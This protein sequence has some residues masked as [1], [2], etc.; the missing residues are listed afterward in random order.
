MMRDMSDPIVWIHG[1]PHAKEIFDAQ[2]AIAGV[3][4]VLVDLPGFGATPAREGIT[5]DGY[6]EAVLEEL[7][8]RGIQRATFA[9]LSMGGYVCFAMLRVGRERVAGLI[10]IDTKETPD[11]DE[12]RKG[13]YAMIEKVQQEGTAPVVESL[14][15][16]MLT[17]NAP[18][19][20]RRRVHEIMS[21]QPAEGVIAALKAMAERPD[22]SPLLPS[23]DVPVLIVVGGED[24]VTPPS[25]A[26]RMGSAIPKSKVVTITGAAHLPNVERPDE[27]NAAVQN[28]LK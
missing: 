1:F 18:D 6:A 12:A 15:P 26:Q 7:D 2:R 24:A 21:A 28:H 20:V 14:L 10:L 9:G 5:I 8:R 22:S 16:K 3:E 25:D 4:H 23:I 17:A 13:R 27:L 19:D 11:S